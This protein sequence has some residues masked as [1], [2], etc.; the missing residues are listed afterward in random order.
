[1]P[2]DI[3][4]ESNYL[5]IASIAVLMVKLSAIPAD[6]LLL[7]HIIKIVRLNILKSSIH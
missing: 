3:D 4:D 6:D 5:S 1:M 2:V 7:L